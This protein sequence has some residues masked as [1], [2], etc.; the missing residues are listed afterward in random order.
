MDW[1]RSSRINC[2]VRHAVSECCKGEFPLIFL[3]DF[4]DYL[5]DAGWREED[6]KEVDRRVA[7]ELAALKVSRE[8]VSESMA[9]D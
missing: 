3:A 9:S 1:L 7:A 6:I 8:I 2:A 5:R 4:A